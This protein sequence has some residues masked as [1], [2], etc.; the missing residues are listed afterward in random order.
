LKKKIQILEKEKVEY[1]K[2]IKNLQGELNLL[3]TKQ[4]FYEDE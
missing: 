1:V 2:E 4:F 3:K